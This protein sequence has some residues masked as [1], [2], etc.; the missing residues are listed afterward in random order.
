MPT[1]ARGRLLP[2]PDHVLAFGCLGIVFR[3]LSRSIQTY[4]DGVCCTLYCIDTKV[5]NKHSGALDRNNVLIHLGVAWVR[6]PT[7][8]PENNGL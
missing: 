4:S 6:E 8:D 5:R 3:L 1:G 7:V 2:H